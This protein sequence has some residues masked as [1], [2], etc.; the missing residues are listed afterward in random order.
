MNG[1][2]NVETVLQI[3]WRRK[4]QEI[5]TH[6]GIGDLPKEALLALGTQPAD[7]RHESPVGVDEIVPGIDQRSGRPAWIACIRRSHRVG[8]LNAG[9]VKSEGERICLGEGNIVLVERH[10]ILRRVG[11]CFN[12]NFAGDSE[13]FKN[14]G[15]VEQ[16][17]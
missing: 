13:V 12:V 15:E 1:C 5:E 4:E 16:E 10:L 9:S 8:R 2:C 14:R 3:Q 7:R 6:P 17:I 11:V